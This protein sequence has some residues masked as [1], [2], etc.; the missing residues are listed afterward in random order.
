MEQLKNLLQPVPPSYKPSWREVLA[1]FDDIDLDDDETA[2]ALVWA[3]QRKKVRL[4]EKLREQRAAE[5][6]RLL[7]KVDWTFEQVDAYAHQRAELLFQS[8]NLDQP[9]QFDDQAKPYY[10]WFC[11][12]F[13]KDPRF[14]DLSQRLGVEHPSFDKGLYMGGN[15]GVGKTTL[16]R[17]FQRNRRQVFTVQNAKAIADMFEVQ[18]QESMSQFVEC[19][20][21]PSNDVENFYQSTMG[22]CIDDM[23]T[24]TLKIHYGNK[25]NVIGD[26]VE[27]RYSKGNIGTLLHITTNLT[28]DQLSNFYGVRV[29]SRLRQCMNVI[30]FMGEDRR[31]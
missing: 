22:L 31:K 12:Y 1:N 17:L 13:S 29:A 8:G 9:F 24:E 19:P 20:E 23:G 27:L 4:Q 15:V 5:N 18:G 6:R 2:E 28:G 11:Y 14:L 26:L 3:K 25:K 30:D 16:M 21:L 7:T 10:L